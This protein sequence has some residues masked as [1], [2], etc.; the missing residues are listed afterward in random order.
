MCTATVMPSFSG[1]IMFP[2]SDSR[3]TTRI[4]VGTEV[5]LAAC[6]SRTMIKQLSPQHVH[7]TGPHGSPDQ[8]LV[9][10]CHRTPAMN[11]FLIVSSKG[12]SKVISIV[13]AMSPGPH[14]YIPEYPCKSHILPWHLSFLLA[15][16]R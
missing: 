2:V 14:L 1:I 12:C 15:K 3:H 16:C 6:W 5:S 8:A 9:N 10:L 4:S 11:G 13:S 7:W